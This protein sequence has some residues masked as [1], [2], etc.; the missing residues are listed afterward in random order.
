[1]SRIVVKSFRA[2]DFDIL[3]DNAIDGS[4]K[5]YTRKE[6]HL[7]GERYERS[8]C[9]FTGWLGDTPLGSLGILEVRPG[10]GNLW[11]ILHKDVRKHVV[12]SMRAVKE[13]LRV[14]EGMKEYDFK[15][16]RSDSRIGFP[17]SQRF[18]EFLG[19][20]RQRRN[21]INGNHFFYRKVLCH[22]QQQ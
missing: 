2:K 21:M 22:Q 15:V 11:S 4:V 8:G 20:T 18:L 14:I 7:F 6:I 17:E 13:M 10:I 3:Y 1:M 16:L 19:F 9:S 12:S 5:G